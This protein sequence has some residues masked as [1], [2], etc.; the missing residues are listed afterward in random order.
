MK[1][2]I[3]ILLALTTAVAVFY[4]RGTLVG[5]PHDPVASAAPVNAEQLAAELTSRLVAAG[6]SDA[7]AGAVVSL[8]LDRFILLRETVEAALEKEF[9]ALESLRPEGVVAQLLEKHPQT[10]GLLVM[11]HDRLALAEGIL[12]I[13]NEDARD[14][15]IGSFAKYMDA[16]DI[17]RWAVAVNRHGRCVA[18]L[19]RRC[20]A[21]PFDAVFVFPQSSPEVTEAYARWLDDV[22]EPTALPADD[23][24]T[25]SLVE[26]IL[27]AG[28]GIRQRMDSN[29]DFRDSFRSELWPAFARCVQRFSD[30]RDIRVAWEFFG[31]TPRIWDLL[32][33]PDGEALFQSAGTLAIDV[34]YGPEAVLPELREK[35]A[36]LLRQENHELVER[37]FGATWSRHPLFGKLMLDRNLTDEQ[38]LA[39]CLKLGP[40]KDDKAEA[41]LSDWNQM[42]DSALA[43]DIGPPPGLRAV[44]PGYAVYYLGKKMMQGR[45]AGWIDAFGVGGDFVT[46]LSLGSSKLITEPAKEAATAALKQKLKSEAAKKVATAALKQKLKGEAAKDV[47]ALGVKEI[48]EEKRMVSFMAHQALRLLPSDLKEQFLKTLVVDVTGLAKGTFELG[49]HSGLGRESFK[50][51]TGLEARIFMRRD[52]K[53]L[54]S[55]PALVAGN[56][57]CAAFLNATAVNGAMDAPLHS[58]PV[59]EVVGKTFRVAS[60]EVTRCNQNLACWWSGLA[61]EAFA[62]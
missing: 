41:M 50:K 48:A 43:E 44:I 11:A 60:D 35:A 22:L 6:W 42:S 18:G 57:P 23:E 17:S 5:Q 29:P 7:A 38:L 32:E 2:A 62:P 49:R 8:S 46:L 1:S 59:Q 28:P 40:E 45:S 54:T 37:A 53:V 12:R 25:V 9:K 47:A 51:L 34:L 13:T 26:F 4:F 14:N 21:W 39:A 19:Q 55:L 36:S 31:A 33:R 27:A 15:I 61:T 20:Q 16:G 10:A 24:D 30:E 52:G 3:A 56:N 58:K